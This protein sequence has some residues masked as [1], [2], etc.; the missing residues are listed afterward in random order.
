ME[1]M[2]NLVANL[3]E[4]GITQNKTFSESELETSF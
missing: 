3:Q 2:E 1:W 4:N